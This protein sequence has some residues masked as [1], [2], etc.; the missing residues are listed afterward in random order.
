M[1]RFTI[2]LVFL[3][4]SPTSNAAD[5]LNSGRELLRKCNSY[6]KA[7]NNNDIMVDLVGGGRCLGLV[8]GI[9][10][11]GTIFNIIAVANNRVTLHI[12]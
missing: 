2:L 10:D 12:F 5:D 11:A 8:R 7:V 3:M 1:K 4:F 9:I 6:I